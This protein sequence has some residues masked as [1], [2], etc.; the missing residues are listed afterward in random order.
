MRNNVKGIHGV[1]CR[2]FSRLWRAASRYW[3]SFTRTLTIFKSF[4]SFQML[5]VHR[6]VCVWRILAIKHMYTHTRICTRMHTAWQFTC[7]LSR[8]LVSS[9]DTLPSQFCCLDSWG[10]DVSTPLLIIGTGHQETASSIHT[11]PQSWWRTLSSRS[12][13][14]L[15]SGWGVA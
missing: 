4:P 9:L 15:H 10:N 11:E 14:H 2:G 12:S 1:S 7:S 3:L 8:E 5:L 13:G 6:I